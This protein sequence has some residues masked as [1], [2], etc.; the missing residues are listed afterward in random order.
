VAL[1]VD[2]S[3]V[4]YCMDC[5]CAFDCQ[6]HSSL[7]AHGNPTPKSRPGLR[8]AVGILCWGHAWRV[9]ERRSFVKSPISLSTRNNSY[10]Q[11][12]RWFS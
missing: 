1:C 6:I 2:C 4:L 3:K 5:S 8:C 12:L 7:L 11:L 9:K 10:I